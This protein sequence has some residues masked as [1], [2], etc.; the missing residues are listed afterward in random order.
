MAGPKILY[1][2][3]FVRELNLHRSKEQLERDFAKLEGNTSEFREFVSRFNKDIPKLISKYGGVK[4]VTMPDVIYVVSRERGLSFP[5][6]LTIVADENQK[7]ML[8]RYVYLI[9]LRHFERQDAAAL[10][11]RY[12]CAKLPMSFER[13]VKELENELTIVV[14]LPYDLE[15]QAFKKWIK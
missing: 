2:F 11:T 8:V 1:S 14:P 3:S 4:T 12:V 13:E 5:E 7:F 15:E 6:P 10:I 9:A